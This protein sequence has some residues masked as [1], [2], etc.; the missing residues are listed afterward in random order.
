[1]HATTPGLQS[2]GEE[3]RPG[4]MRALPRSS[5][6]RSGHR[7]AAAG[8]SGHALQQQGQEQSLGTGE[9]DG[10]GEATSAE[11]EEE[12]GYGGEEVEE[13]MPT[14]E[15]EA[16]PRAQLRGR[17]RAHKVQSMFAAAGE[18]EAA[19]EQV[20]VWSLGCECGW[21][22]GPSVPQVCGKQ[23]L[24]FSSACPCL[25]ASP[26]PALVNDRSRLQEQQLQQASEE[27]EE[28][29]PAIP[30]RTR[31]GSQRQPAAVD[32]QPQ[33][34]AAVEESEEEEERPARRRRR[35]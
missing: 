1:M 22:G 18:E 15:E 17:R 25:V 29:L 21:V 34:L 32:P 5:G 11:E 7:S 24:L 8:G 16:L 9:D 12:E 2:E 28:D 13:V 30:G 4:A 31:G 27:E 35:R 23:R 14:M 10:E 26:L 3:E 33:L 19:D 20:R 6:Q